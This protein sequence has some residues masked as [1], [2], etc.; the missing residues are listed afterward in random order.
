MPP[1]A[2]K[3]VSRCSNPFPRSFV[4]VRRI[5]AVTSKK[6]KRSH[7]QTYAPETPL[8]VFESGAREGP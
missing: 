1:I 5:A 7:T 4:I 3:M 8:R 6:V 2:T